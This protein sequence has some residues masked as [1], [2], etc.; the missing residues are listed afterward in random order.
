MAGKIITPKRLAEQWL[1]LPNKFDVN[2]LNFETLAGDAAVYVFKQSFNL[3]RFNSGSEPAWPSRHDHNPWP[4]LHETGTMKDSI[5]VKKRS[6]KHKVIVWTD[7]AEYISSNRGSTDPYKYGARFNK[8]RSIGF[9]YAAIH[10]EG[11]S[12]VGARGGAGFIKKRQFM[13]Y[14]TVLED[15]LKSLSVRIFDGFPK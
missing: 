13:G 5:K 8:N 15:K 10:N 7:D 12:A 11:G 1:R 9:V 14:S 3:C 6:P 4:L 2:V